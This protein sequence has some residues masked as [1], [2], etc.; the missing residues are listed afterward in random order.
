MRFAIAVATRCGRLT[1][2]AL[3]YPVTLYFF[4]R[5]GPERRASREYLERVLGRRVTAWHVLRHI[6]CFSCTIL[7]RL[8]MFSEGF[9]RF[10]IRT[11]GVEELEEA[12]RKGRGL[13]LMGSHLGSFD[14]LRVLSH[15]RSDVEVRI[16]LD[17]EQ[18]PKLSALLNALNPSL[19]AG[20]INARQGGPATAIAI[21]EALDRNAIVALAA[22]RGQP[23]NAMQAA[24]FLGHAAPLPTAP[25]LL[26]AA[27]K[28]PVVLAFGLYRGGNRYDLHFETFSERV[29]IERRQRT[30]ALGH[31]LQ[32]FADRLAH[33]ARLAPYNWFNFYDFWHTT[34]TSDPGRPGADHG[35]VAEPRD[36]L[37]RS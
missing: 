8:F 6:H 37:R 4:F 12:M 16:V 18:N 13:L 11:S 20:I 2:R 28:V 34:P 22:D 32:R 23:H 27:L 25:W 35:T 31:V 9:R 29:S 1:A 17:V 5:R 30:A 33:Y 10:D 21:R 24:S 15:E 26:A 14:A 7:D 36:L 19:A 3:L